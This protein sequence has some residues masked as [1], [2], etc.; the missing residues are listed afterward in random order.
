MDAGLKLLTFRILL[1]ESEVDDQ[2][3]TV[4]GGLFRD[5]FPF[6]AFKTDVGGFLVGKNLAHQNV[7]IFGVCLAGWHR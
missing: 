3:F 5:V 2:I 7:K 4:D 6:H 1:S